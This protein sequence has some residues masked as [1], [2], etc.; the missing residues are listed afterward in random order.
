[1]LGQ[2][3]QKKDNTPS[4]E[5]RFERLWTN[6]SVSRTWSFSLSG[7][8]KKKREACFSRHRARRSKRHAHLQRRLF[9]RAA[10]G[11]LS[12][13]TC[14]AGWCCHIPVALELSGGCWLAVILVQKLPGKKTAFE[15]SLYFILNHRLLLC[16]GSTLFQRASDVAF[17]S[18]CFLEEDFWKGLSEVW[19]CALSLWHNLV[20]SAPSCAFLAPPVCM[21]TCRAL[22][23]LCWLPGEISTHTFLSGQQAEQRARGLCI[24]STYTLFK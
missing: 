22:H 17:L 6:R 1:M 4:W 9:P 20:P 13:G 3:K 14:G 15:E 23:K 8:E 16:R 18:R 2:N 21:T 5:Q 7:R 19:C 11:E 10:G 24:A 12:W